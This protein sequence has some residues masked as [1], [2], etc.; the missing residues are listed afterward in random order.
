M[1]EA[2]NVEFR[3]SLYMMLPGY[4]ELLGTHLTLH[5]AYKL[6]RKHQRDEVSS[7]EIWTEPS[8]GR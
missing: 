4:S 3:Y 8:E 1:T 5:G 2:K 6:M 7:F